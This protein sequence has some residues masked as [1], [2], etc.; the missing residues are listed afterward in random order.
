MMKTTRRQ[1]LAGLAAMPLF[2]QEKNK[3]APEFIDGKWLNSAAPIKLADRRGK[4]TV[5]HFWTYACIN[6]KR[7]MP[8]YN[9]WYEEFSKQGVEII[10]V[11]TP[12]LEFEYNPKFI[13]EHTAKYGVKYPVLLDLQHK[14]W[15]RWDQQYW[16]TVYLIDKKG[17]IRGNWEGELEY[18]NAGGD[19]KMA[20][21]IRSLL[22]EA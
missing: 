21:M 14:N 7:N 15:Q 22:N 17:K 8:I 11:H 20:G 16:P 18:R 13:A 6:C 5:V 1:L 4:V 9:K 12:E 10:G 19:M 2:A 3:P